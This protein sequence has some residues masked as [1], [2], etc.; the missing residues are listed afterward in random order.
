MVHASKEESVGLRKCEATNKKEI[1]FRAE[2]GIF[3]VLNEHF[4]LTRSHALAT[5]VRF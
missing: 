4:H 3:A 1:I 2:T 5:N